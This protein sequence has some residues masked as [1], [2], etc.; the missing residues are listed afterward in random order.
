MEARG[1]AQLPQA[2][3]QLG[4]L[5]AQLGLRDVPQRGR[6]DVQLEDAAARL[7]EG[8]HMYALEWS[9]DFMW[10]YVDSWLTHMLELK[11]NE[12]FWNRG[13]FP[14]SCRTGPTASCSR[15]RG[16]TA[17]ATSFDQP[18]YLITNVAVG[19]TNGWFPDGPEKPWLDGSATAPLDFL[20]A[21]EKW[22]KTWPQDPAERAMH[23]DEG[24]SDSVKMWE[25]C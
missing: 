5:V 6:Q 22:Y 23:A 1:N 15:T 2:G 16:S 21:Q 4:A 19:G 8:F 25:K 13:D 12:P 3:H 7:D 10:M 18:F 14:P 17:K 11:I 24:Y 20:R 9:E